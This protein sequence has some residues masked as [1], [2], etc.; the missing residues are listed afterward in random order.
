MAGRTTIDGE[1]PEDDE[2]GVFGNCGLP[3][4]NKMRGISGLS[5][6]RLTSE[7][8]ICSME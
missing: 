8:G 1:V 2:C 6:N 3:K 7:E 5:A 4:V